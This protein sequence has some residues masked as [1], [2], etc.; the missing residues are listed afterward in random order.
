MGLVMEELNNL[1]KAMKCYENALHLYPS[2]GELYNFKGMVLTQLG[3]YKKAVHCF[4]KAIEL[5]P[6][7]AQALYN[8]R[9]A[10]EKYKKANFFCCI[11]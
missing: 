3:K 8:K 9:V 7:L 6:S 11:V 10:E 5:K 2:D 1:N 4:E